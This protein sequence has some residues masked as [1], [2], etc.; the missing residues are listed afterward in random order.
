MTERILRQKNYELLAETLQE[1]IIDGDLRPGDELPPERVLMEDYGV[2]RS[3]VRE[4]LRILESRGLITQPGN[5]FTVRELANAL[6]GP[7]QL[8]ASV[9]RLSTPQLFEV[10]ETMEIAIAGAAAERRD[11]ADLDALLAAHVAMLE[12][13]DERSRIEADVRFHVLV[14]RASRNP[15]YEHVMVGVRDVLRRAL[16]RIRPLTPVAE[17]VAEQHRAILDAIEDG[18]PDAARAAMAHHL[19]E[20]RREMDETGAISEPTGRGRRSRSR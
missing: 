1:R 19:A 5:G 2:G 7:M 16:E 18:D 9:N 13:P 14:A 3:S 11:D 20:V 6:G 15:L 17:R 10:R 12:A 8:V 4:A